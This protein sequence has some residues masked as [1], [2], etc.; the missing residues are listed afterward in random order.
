MRRAGLFPIVALAAL[1]PA[2]LLFGCAVTSATGTDRAFL[3]QRRWIDSDFPQDLCPKLDENVNCEKVSGPFVAD[4]VVRVYNVPYYHVRFENGKEGYLVGFIAESAPTTDLAIERKQAVAE[5][6]RRGQPK[7]GMT[8]DQV[9]STCWGKPYRVNRT[10]TG[11]HTHDQFV[12]PSDRYL[13]FSDGILTSI[14]M[15]GALR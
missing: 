14:Q 5:C 3:G 8:T 11:T 1:L 2:S 6:A 15:S 9:Y 10:Q 7:I 12:Y 13:Y 4:D